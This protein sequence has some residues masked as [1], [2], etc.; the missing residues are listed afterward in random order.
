[1]AE[2]QSEGGNGVKARKARGNFLLLLT[3]MI[4]G[5]SFV[6]QSAGADLISPAFFNGTRMLLGSLLLSPLAVYRM[7]RYVPASSRRT[8][9]LGGACCGVLMFTGSYI[10]QTGIAYTT[11]GK[12]G[13]LTAIYVVLVPVLGI[14]LKKKPRPILWVSV[15]LACVG[16]YF[17]CF[18]DKTFSLA[19]GDAAMLGGAVMFALH[20][21]VVDHFSPLVDGVCLS[22]VQFLTAGSL[23]MVVAF[24]TEQPSFAALSA[25]AVPILY[26]GV[27]TMGVA[28]TLQIVAQKDTDP[29]VASLILC[30]ESVFAVVFGWLILHET[31]SLREGVGSV[32]MFVA[33]LLAQLA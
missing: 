17:L 26:T 28:Y 25:A 18:T 22:F 13:F 23:G 4:W 3:A 6:A 32:F 2:K 5:S 19:M 24:I 14:F 9:L 1:V 11:A 7:R 33:V 27:F 8:L 20:I 12:A 10:Q 31:L 30:M 21:M 16:L 15:A 29:T